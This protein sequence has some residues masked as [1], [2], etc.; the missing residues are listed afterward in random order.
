MRKTVAV[1]VC[2]LLA[3][4]AGYTSIQFYEASEQHR[5]EYRYQPAREPGFHI[6]APKQT[7]APHY[8]PSCNNPNTNSDA[9]LCAQW[10]AVDQVTES[11]RLASIN[12]K[13]TLFASV[14]TLLGTVFVGFALIETYSTSRQQLRAYLVIRNVYIRRKSPSVICVDVENAGETPANEVR[15]VSRIG[16]SGFEQDTPIDFGPIG[17]RTI[18]FHLVQLAKPID[19]QDRFYHFPFV[20]FE[21]TYQDAFKRRWKSTWPFYLDLRGKREG[22][23]MPL[24]LNAGMKDEKRA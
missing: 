13:L 18:R 22:D 2:A 1:S 19:P 12:T 20:E 11:N 14:L 17:P 4:G 3:L 15:I 16:V 23:T 8:K 9:D 10:A 24:A 6:L 5:A 7:I 21:V